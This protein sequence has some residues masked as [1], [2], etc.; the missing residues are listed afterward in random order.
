MRKLFDLFWTFAK[1]GA[2]CFG[3]GYA[4]LPLLEREIV[5]KRSWATQ[6]ELLDY[7][8]IGQCT[9]GIIAINVSTFIGYK[10]G[11]IAG[12]LAA[13]AGMVFFPVI[14]ILV[15]AGL[16][17]NYAE[18]PYVKR[19]FSGIAVCVCVLIT[20]A[21]SKLWKKSVKNKMGYIIFAVVLLSALFTNIS[22]GFF[23][24]GA[25]IAGLIFSDLVRSKK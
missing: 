11:G 14:I 25:A 23:I 22:S 12:A 13:T 16:L 1:M 7:Y 9:P 10:R 8:A 15:I 6:E 21:V 2:V 17:A 24:L 4:M 18:N 19:A 3:G 20:D 5:T